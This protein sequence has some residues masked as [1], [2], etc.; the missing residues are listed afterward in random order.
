MA[1]QPRPELTTIILTFNSQSSIARV[2]QACQ[3]LSSRI[4]VVDSYSS[5][6]TLDIVRSFDCEVVQHEF[7]NY[8]VQRNW[9][10]AYAQIDPQGWVLHLDSDEVLSPELA[11]N[12]QSALQDLDP[13]IDGFLMQRLSY[14]L[15]KPLRYGYIN[16]SWHLR[17]YQASKGCCE[18]RLY[19]QHFVVP[20]RTEKLPGLMIDLQE[21][22]LEKWIASHNRWSTAE[23]EQVSRQQAELR[24][25]QQ[26]H[27]D[28]HADR[29][30]PETLSGDQRMRRRWLKNHLYYQ[31]PLFLRS[32]L[33][34]IYSY[35]FRLGFLDGRVGLIYNVLQAFWFRFLVDAK[36]AERELR[37]AEPA[38][39]LQTPAQ[40][41]AQPAP[42]VS[43]P[44]SEPLHPARVEGEPSDVPSH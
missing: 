40:P 23:A 3:P 9:A 5:D 34:F 1:D 36:L 16:P 43:S 25:A 19:D 18:D 14:F 38:S 4:V 24:Q 32:F 30:L 22:S 33:F 11:Q 26:G 41:Q 27:P 7:E 2:L 6:Q 29:H 28:P 21:I 15:G 39:P 10:Q 44:V 8:S 17:L 20:G 12:I 37:A 31:S 35:I 42:V 13:T